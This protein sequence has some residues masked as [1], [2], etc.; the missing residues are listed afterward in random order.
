MFAQFGTQHRW[1]TQFNNTGPHIQLEEQYLPP[2]HAQT[3]SQH[4]TLPHNPTYSPTLLGS[5]DAP[6]TSMSQRL[7]VPHQLSIRPQ[8]I[9]DNGINANAFNHNAQGTYTSSP[10]DPERQTPNIFY[11]HTSQKHVFHQQSYPT[12]APPQIPGQSTNA[13]D[14]LTPSMRWETRPSPQFTSSS[15]SLDP[16]PAQGANPAYYRIDTEQP[17]RQTFEFD[18]MRSTSGS[19]SNPGETAASQG[20]LHQT[21]RVRPNEDDDNPSALYIDV[22]MDHEAQ[23]SQDSKGPSK[24]K[25]GACARCKSLKVRQLAQTGLI[26]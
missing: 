14:S 16:P 4:F 11:P 24:M 15:L 26:P 21:K 23:G 18:M 7:A 3:H 25:L 2:Q 17:Q 9:V 5:Y 6:P 13:S 12:E 10:K 19:Q 8:A 22:G 20:Y 1:A